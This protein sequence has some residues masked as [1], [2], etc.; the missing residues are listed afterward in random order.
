MLLYRPV[1]R[2]A[3]AIRH[4][5]MA[6][7]LILVT[8]TIRA[9]PINELKPSNSLIILTRSKPLKSR[10]IFRRKKYECTVLLSLR[11]FVWGSD[12]PHSNGR[13][14]YFVSNSSSQLSTSSLKVFIWWGRR[15]RDRYFRGKN[16]AKHAWITQLHCWSF[17]TSPDRVSR[18]IAVRRQGWINLI[19]QAV[20][21]V[22]TIEYSRVNNNNN[23]RKEIGLHFHIVRS[24]VDV[25]ILFLKA[26]LFS[27]QRWLSQG[28]SRDFHSANDL[29]VPMLFSSFLQ[30]CMRGC[31]EIYGPEKSNC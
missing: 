12:F 23:A 24:Y 20:M 28:H 3:L 18:I 15:I 13:D 29:L 26:S 5:H 31:L 7:D 14:D 4:W 16:G 1:C 30:L 8:K 10:P 17:S 9:I 19:Y 22:H 25:Q 21:R 2:S 11:S 27:K 6:N